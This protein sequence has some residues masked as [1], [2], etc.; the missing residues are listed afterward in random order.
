MRARGH[1]DEHTPEG[2]GF[3]TWS[4]AGVNEART[5]LS[6]QSDSKKGPFPPSTRREKLS[7]GGS[8]M[9]ALGMSV[10]GSG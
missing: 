5:E 1:E 8:R 9:P 7:T 3:R 6:A 2:R 4:G 10:L